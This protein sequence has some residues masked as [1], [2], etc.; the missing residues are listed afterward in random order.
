LSS[1]ES[2]TSIAN[3]EATS[4]VTDTVYL[5]LSRLTRDTNGN[6]VVTIPMLQ[7]TNNQVSLLVSQDGVYPIT[8]RIT[9]DITN[10]PISSVLTFINRRNIDSRLP[11]VQATTII[12]L[13]HSPSISPSGTFEVTPE[14][15][16][17]AQ[18]FIDYLGKNTRAATVYVQPETIAALATSTDTNDV[19]LIEGIRNQL[20]TRSI[21]TATFAPTDVS[22]MAN[23][24]L[25][26]EFISQL[27]LGESTLTKYL[28]GINIVRNTW[29]ANDLVDQGGLELLHK[30]GITGLVLLRGGQDGAKYQAPRSVLAR[31]DGSS[32]QFMSVISVDA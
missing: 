31:P 2:L 8:I 4:S 14:L 5:R 6:L 28:P 12:S 21:T 23:A 17:K 16:A 30:A 27:R 29:V 32:Q 22:M 26:D 11:T 7:A 25:D 20:R 24:S 13:T 19:A 18:R 1:R 15:R 9:D 3:G 10:K